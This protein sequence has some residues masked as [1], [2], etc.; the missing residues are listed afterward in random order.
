MQEKKKEI[1]DVQALPF[2]ANYNWSVGFIMETFIKGLA[3]RKLLAAKCPECEYTYVPPRN[4]CGQCNAEIK[5]KNLVP[6]S[7]K[8]QLEG[9]TLA[10]VQPDEEGNFADLEEPGMIGAIRLEGADSTLY[11]PIQG[12]APEDVQAGMKVEAAWRKKTKGEIA[13]LSFF[14]PS[15]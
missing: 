2:V 13:D 15:K 10:Y 14:K 12:V 5:E 9:F 7:G 8:G 3:K 11:M 4:R 6:L 1:V